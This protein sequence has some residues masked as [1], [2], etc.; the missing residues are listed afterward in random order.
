[1]PSARVAVRLRQR[2]R[3]PAIHDR[4]GNGGEIQPGRLLEDAQVKVIG[5]CY[6]VVEDIRLDLF[7]FGPIGGPGVNIQ[8]NGQPVLCG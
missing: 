2:C 5:C 4:P 3:P 1:M 7:V 8:F 6:Q